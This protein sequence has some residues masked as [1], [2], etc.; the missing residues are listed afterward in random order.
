MCKQIFF[1][2]SLF[3]WII[4]SAQVT[5]R[6]IL[7][8]KYSLKDISK[9]LVSQESFKPYPTTP[10]EWRERI[11]D[12][13]INYLVKEGEENLN[14]K[15]IDIPASVLLEFKRTGNR[16][17]HQ[18]IS[19][20]KRVALL[21]L[22]LAES[23][24]GKGRFLDAIIDGSWSLC[25]ESYWGIPAHIRETEGIP[26]IENPVVDLFT[27]ETAST[28]ALVDYFAGDKM[29]K[30]SPLFR[31]RIRYEIN[32]RFFTPLIQ[33]MNTDTYAYLSKVNK[34]NNWCAWIMT[35]W[36]NTTLL[37]EKDKDKRAEMVYDAMSGMD[38]Y[39]NGT[40]DEGGCE[41]GPDYWHVAGGAILHSLEWLQK[42][43]NE[44]VNV[45]ENPFIHKVASY[46]YKVNIGKKDFVNIGDNAP[47]IE[48]LGE[49]YY[50]VGM[51]LGDEQMKQFG[52][53]ESQG[54]GHA[55]TFDHI[56]KMRSIDDY[57]TSFQLPQTK[58]DYKPLTHSWISDIQLMGA[59]SR[60][61]LYLASHAS[62]NGKSH[63]HND[64]GDFSIYI[65]DDAFIVDAGKCTYTAKTFSDRRYE[66]WNTQSQYHNLP[67]INGYGQ[68][69][70]TKYG[71]KDVVNTNTDSE[72]KLVMNIAP[73]YPEKA[74]LLSWKR[75][76]SLKRE[77]DD[78]TIT[79]E[80][81]FKETPIS[82]QQVFLTVANV[83]VSKEGTILFE[84][85]KDVLKLVYDASV[86]SVSMDK[87][88][89][90]N[91]DYG[92]IKKNWHNK[93]ITRILLTAKKHDISGKYVYKFSKSG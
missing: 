64:V 18:G 85:D 51:H 3:S 25:E 61:N 50:R 90:V 91:P 8:N 53:W 73:A 54:K 47:Q 71:A 88:S 31:K 6:N 35:N 40:G 63:N 65:N 44:K 87:P 13:G 12:K 57:I 27:S 52:L 48:P 60:N 37:V 79:D 76:S 20:K 22:V 2:L 41:E 92:D 89:M 30:V 42:A 15:F 86:F 74:G 19:F 5:Q 9:S 23:A 69:V 45:Y 77:S 80:Y 10:D 33:N 78:I 75:T 83:D 67:I 59:R 24:E 14:F 81:S 55:I 36:L 16:S 38:R 7:T 39:L 17:H 21:R 28:L 26:D 84:G 58:E 34:V 82:I 93:V 56:L 68:A 62:N 29:D 4:A 1:W 11:S 46:I 72:D 66:L 70:G 32:R 43:T 49:F